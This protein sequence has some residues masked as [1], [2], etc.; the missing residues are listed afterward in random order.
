MMILG[1]F[2]WVAKTPRRLT[3][4]ELPTISS[5]FVGRY[6]SILKREQLRN[7]TNNLE[8]KWE[9]VNYHGSNLC[10]ADSGRWDDEEGPATAVSEGIFVYFKRGT[11]KI[12]IY[13][14]NTVTTTISLQKF[15]LRRNGG[16]LNSGWFVR[17][18]FPRIHQLIVTFLF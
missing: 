2:P 12:K 13:F 16:K 1:A 3:V 14:I 4:S 6:F 15:R 10:F 18:F 5:N 7:G 17:I 11:W 8:N 9:N